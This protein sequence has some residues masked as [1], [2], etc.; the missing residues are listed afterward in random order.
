MTHSELNDDQL[1]AGLRINLEW[2]RDEALLSRFM[3]E[4][5]QLCLKRCRDYISAAM[6]DIEALTQDKNDSGRLSS[7]PENE[8][9]PEAGERV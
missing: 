8:T 9:D 4:Q 7:A 6:A 3:K 1:L 5:R 2:A